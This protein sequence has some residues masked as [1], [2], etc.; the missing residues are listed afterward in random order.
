MSLVAIFTL[1][2]NP[3]LSLRNVVGDC[4]K[5]SRKCRPV[6]TSVHRRRGGWICIKLATWPSL[7]SANSSALSGSTACG[8]PRRFAQEITSG[9]SGV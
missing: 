1:C 6:R 8:Y 3:F 7:S 9:N 5:V 2:T 4:W